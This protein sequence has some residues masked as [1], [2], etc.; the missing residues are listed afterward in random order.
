[1]NNVDDDDNGYVDDVIGYDFSKTSPSDTNA[2]GS[3]KADP[4]PVFRIHGT[5]TSS[6]AGG[7]T[8]NLAGISSAGFNCRLMILS[9]DADT[10]NK[11]S[12]GTMSTAT[13]RNALFYAARNGA[14]IVNMSLGLSNN[15]SLKEA[16]DTAFNRGL[17]L[18]AATG[19][20]GD[21]TI[22]W[23]AS[24]REVLGVTSTDSADVKSSFGTYNDS[25]DLTAPAANWVA[26]MS[27]ANPNPL[28]PEWA[29][30]AENLGG[31]TFCDT[32]TF[33]PF[34]TGTS[35][36]APLVA[37]VSGLIK[38][39]YPTM[40]NTQI[41]YKLK[42][43]TDPVQFPDS[44]NPPPWAGKV[45]T[46]RLNAFKAVTF[47]D[48]IPK[49]AT[50]TTLSG[51]IY[52][53]GDLVVPA[54][55]TLTLAAGTKFKYVPGDV[56][57][58]S[59][60]PSPTRGQII[61]KGTL[62]CLGNETDSVILTSF[63]TSPQIGDWG[64]ILIAPNGRAEINFTRISYADTAVCVRADTATVKIRN[65]TFTHF[66]TFAVFST[67]AKTDMGKLNITGNCGKN[68]ILMKTAQSG[69]IGARK[70]TSPSGTFFA[71]GNWWD[72]TS[73]PSS[74]FVGSVDKDPF[75]LGM[76][77]P[78][79]CPIESGFG[80]GGGGEESMVAVLPLTFE[81]GQNYP[82]PFNPSTTIRYSIPEA[83][84]VEIKVYNILGQVVRTLIDQ[85]QGS[86]IYQLLW[87]GKDRSGRNVSTGIYFYQIRAGSYVQTKKMILAK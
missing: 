68:N 74:W 71:E 15:P 20:S 77:T 39:A 31:G 22:Y 84:R 79:S 55:K 81:L 80:S 76:A 42:S 12:S 72:S 43:S 46:G 16:V 66:K 32:C 64:G 54:G 34:Q 83:A 67:S 19:N 63:Q 23:P 78:D 70:T 28:A 25:V 8:N 37:G 73:P 44:N 61:V 75:L 86:G 49:M 41:M 26:W 56:M 24:Y 33:A 21:T 38:S 3:P 13:V 10:S 50:D 45:G 2:D 14:D 57:K 4:I 69:A 35:L 60:N 58:A 53:S 1:M 6:L 51:T 9:A 7:V 52:V 29:F 47:F 87:D 82:N 17:V 85:E 27:T 36:S 30:G 40:T 59:G 18:V 48:T 62:K 11:F 65:S 5:A